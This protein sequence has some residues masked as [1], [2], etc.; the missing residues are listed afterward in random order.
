[1]SGLTA[2]TLYGKIDFLYR[3]CLAFA[4]SRERALR[5]LVLPRLRISVDRREYMVNWVHAH[6]RRNLV[7]RAVGSADNDSGYVFG[8]HIA[9]DPELEPAAVE[10]DVAATA[11]DKRPYPHRRYARVWLKKDYDEALDE[12]AEEAARRRRAFGRK[13]TD[14]IDAAYAA[15]EAREDTEVADLKAKDQRLPER[16]MQVHEEYTL[17]AHFFFLRHLLQ[18]VGK[19]R[20]F[21][22]QESGIRAALMAAFSDGVIERRVDGFYVRTAKEMTVTEK[23]SLV[24]KARAIFKAF[25]DA[26]P[27]M[28]PHEIQ[29]EMMKAEIARAVKIGKWSDR[30]CT[31]PWP[32]M[33]EPDK[34][35]CWLTD[36]G[37]YDV[38]HQARLYLR[39]S[40]SG[41][42][43][44]FQRVRRSLNPLERPIST[45]SRASR[46]WHGYSPYNPRLVE[47]LLTIYRVMHNFVEKGKDG[48][49]PAMRLGLAAAPIRAEDI[50]YFH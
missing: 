10:R 17:Y 27:A 5:E 46:V 29:V 3:Q 35:A 13:L 40:L 8:M 43:N 22:D 49:T 23:R 6:D 24:T 36:L 25:E 7:L 48:K 34:K 33:Q 32:S 38:D 42:D 41:I 15:S 28:A 1:V 44:F 45:A 31:H 19:L 4:A 39:A 11:D 26:H 16:G 50:I 30:W 12:M 37:D 47:S 18:N 21:L 9:F 20:F 14:K 2:P